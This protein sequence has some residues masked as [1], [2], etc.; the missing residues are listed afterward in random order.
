MWD[1]LYHTH[2]VQEIFAT[3]QLRELSPKI[4][5]ISKTSYNAAKIL[6]EMNLEMVN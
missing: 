4:V 6:A 3:S 5:I 2:F 1:R